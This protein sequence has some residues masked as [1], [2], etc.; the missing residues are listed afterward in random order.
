MKHDKR[1]IKLIAMIVMF[2]IS[3]TALTACLGKCSNK[4]T[5]N[6]TVESVIVTESVETT[7]ASEPTATLTV[8]VKPTATPKPT[9]AI[10]PTTAVAE[11]GDEST[12][13]TTTATATPTTA[14]TKPTAATPTEAP[15][16]QPTA[17]EAPAPTTQPTATEAPAATATPTPEPT[18]EPTPEPTEAP[19]PLLYCTADVQVNAGAN[20]KC[21]DFVIYGVT[22]ERKSEDKPW[23]PY[24]Y[25]SLEAEIYSMYGEWYEAT[26]GEPCPGCAGYSDQYSNI[27]DIRANP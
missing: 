22:L 19:E 18:A 14:E 17:T 11:D 13:V 6:E 10:T 25:D 27:R 5:A 1:N 23:H 7:E 2:G 20:D 24:D 21:T 15:A 16:T 3:A 9:A 4:G 12:E 26:Y 8:T